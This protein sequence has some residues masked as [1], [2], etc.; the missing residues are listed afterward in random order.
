METTDAVIARQCHSKHVSVATDTDATAKDV[1]FSLQS[2]W[3]LYKEDQLN[4]SVK[5]TRVEAG[6]NTSTVTLRVI[7]G[8]EKG[9]LNSETVKYGHETK[10]TQT[11]KGMH[12]RG[13]VGYTR[14]RPVLP[15]ERVPHKNR[16][17]IVK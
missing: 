14:D 3:S 9:S 11:Q 5:M 12:W 15:S 8:D 13:Q 7:G 2:T 17:V 1:V 16:T 10:G 6:S 4:N